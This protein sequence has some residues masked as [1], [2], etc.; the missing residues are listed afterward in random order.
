MKRKSL[1]AAREFGLVVGG[2]FVLL[3]AWWLYRGK[4]ASAAHIILPLGS[5]LVLLGLIWPRALVLPNKAW[6]LLAEG[7]SFVSTRIILAAVFFLVVTPIG[8][9]KRLSGW[10]PLSRR[11][12]GGTSYW[13]P[14]SERQRDKRHYEKMF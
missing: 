14:Y 3:G 12:A 5:L 13:R 8:V 2:V 4:F 9:V 11:S 7:L 6:M 10:D 1:R